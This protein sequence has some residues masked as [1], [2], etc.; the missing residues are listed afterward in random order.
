M[1]R[2]VVL[3]NFLCDSNDLFC[4]L[5]DTPGSSIKSALG[6]RVLVTYNDGSEVVTVM[7]GGGGTN[8]GSSGS[9]MDTPP[10]G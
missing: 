5:N 8:N 9:W 10:P 1:G 7:N 4:P 3:S 6:V 2:N